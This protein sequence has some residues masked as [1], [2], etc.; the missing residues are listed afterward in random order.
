MADSCIIDLDYDK[1]NSVMK[2]D[3]FSVIFF[4]AK[5]S[6]SSRLMKE[7][8]ESVASSF[9]CEEDSSKLPKNNSKSGKKSKSNTVSF[10]EVDI[11]TQKVPLIKNVPTICIVKNKEVVATKNG[12][13]SEANIIKWITEK[14]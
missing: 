6:G 1:F 13:D 10:Y 5:W 8:L 3:G 12:I 11:D 4:S 2:S 9:Q 14:I 7:I